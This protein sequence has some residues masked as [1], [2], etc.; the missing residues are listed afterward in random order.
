MSENHGMTT[1]SYRSPQSTPRG[2]A[3]ARLARGERV[4]ASVQVLREGGENNL[5]SHEASDGLWFVLRG[6]VKWYGDGDAL[7]ATLN[8]HDGVL[9]PRGT[10]YWFEQTGDEPLELLHVTSTDPAFAEKRRDI[11]TRTVPKAPEL[12]MPAAPGVAS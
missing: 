1:F 10:P 6:S 5:H 11:Q 2:K 12:E 7:V 3:I 8:Q 9:V 4:K